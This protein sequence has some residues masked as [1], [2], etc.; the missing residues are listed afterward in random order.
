MKKINLIA[1]PMIAIVCG[2][3]V[4][5]YGD[6]QLLTRKTNELARSLSLEAGDRKVTRISKNKNLSA[7]LARDL[8]CSIKLDDYQSHYNYSQLVEAHL[9]IGLTYG[10]CS[11]QISELNI[12]SIANETANI[13]AEFIISTRNNDESENSKNVSVNLVW[14]KDEIKLR[15]P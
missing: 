1:I 8:S 14:S 13:L 2:F 9:H 3:L 11:V 15:S 7:L 5:W 10:F 12:I 4:W 6:T